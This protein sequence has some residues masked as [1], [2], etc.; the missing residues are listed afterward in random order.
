MSEREARDFESLPFASDAVK[1]RRWDDEAKIPGW[2]VPPL[3]H[4]R[5]HLQQC[6]GS[7]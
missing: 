2:A 1:L 6:L 7:R 3:E 4:Y 5:A